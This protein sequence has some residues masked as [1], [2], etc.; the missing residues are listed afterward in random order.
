[1]MVTVHQLLFQH[2][3]PVRGVDPPVV[4][5]LLL[6]AQWATKKWDRSSSPHHN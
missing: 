3:L 1:M 5:T 6:L 4:K 2:C